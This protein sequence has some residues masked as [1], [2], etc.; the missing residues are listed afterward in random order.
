M[1]LFIVRRYK[2]ITVNKIHEY[3]ISNTDETLKC[4]DIFISKI[5]FSH[6]LSITMS[7]RGKNIIFTAIATY[8]FHTFTH[9]TCTSL[10]L[11]RTMTFIY[12]EYWWILNMLFVFLDRHRSL[13]G[14]SLLLIHRLH[15][16][17]LCEQYLSEF[18]TV[19]TC[20]FLTLQSAREKSEILK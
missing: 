7:F 10:H 6:E 18:V 19:V 12:D 4:C 15:F 14:V 16:Y 5:T 20:I 13:K 9:I 8:T 11:N 1:Y 17:I 2:Q 3:T